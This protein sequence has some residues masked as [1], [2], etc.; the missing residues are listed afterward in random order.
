MEH[1]LA[2]NNL[3]SMQTLTAQQVIDQQAAAVQQHHEDQQQQQQQQ[4]HQNTIGHLLQAQATPENPAGTHVLIQHTINGQTN[5]G[6][7]TQT[8]LHLPAEALA[9]MGMTPVAVAQNS[10][11]GGEQ[12]TVVPMSRIGSTGEMT[13]PLGMVG[14]T[15]ITNIP[16]DMTTFMNL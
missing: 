6:G 5:T 2:P 4:Q 7:Q 15:N 9:Q 11:Q 10:L 16:R 14:M 1:T 3:P 8:I 13:L 12:L